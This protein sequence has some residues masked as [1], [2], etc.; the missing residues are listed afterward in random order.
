MIYFK[1]ITLAV[2]YFVNSVLA[3]RERLKAPLPEVT[4]NE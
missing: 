2:N 4:K 3:G 1:N